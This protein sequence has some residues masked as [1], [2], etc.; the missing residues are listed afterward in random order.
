M[1]VDPSLDDATRVKYMVEWVTKAHT[2]LLHSGLTEETLKKAVKQAMDVGGMVPRAGL[3][4]FFRTTGEQGV[5]VLVFSAGIANVLEEVLRR[6]VGSIPS[7]VDVASNRILFDAH[8]RITGFGHPVFHV[9]NKRAC[10]LKQGSGH[11]LDKIR[12]RDN[13]VLIGDSLGDLNMSVGLEGTV[14]ILRIG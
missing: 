4:H 13:V 8:G 11:I 12:G 6:A 9:F 14:N 1:A 3:G 2:L 5:P 10:A 7:H